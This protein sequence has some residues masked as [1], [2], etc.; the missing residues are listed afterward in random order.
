MEKGHLVFV[1]F[2]GAVKEKD[3]V[4]GGEELDGRRMTEK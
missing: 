4:V 2:V 3:G 1:G